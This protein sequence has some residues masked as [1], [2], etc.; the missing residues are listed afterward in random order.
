MKSKY[1]K[2]IIV[3][4][5][6]IV[7]ILA[8]FKP[9]KVEAALITYEDKSVLPAEV[10]K[11]GTEQGNK[12]YFKTLDD[13]KLGI[14]AWLEARCYDYYKNNNGKGILP[15]V[16]FCQMG[17]ET[18]W[19][20]DKSTIVKEANNLLCLKGNGSRG[21]Y[22]LSKG[23]SFANFANWD[24]C[25]SF[26]LNKIE[27]STAN[28][29]RQGQ[30][31]IINLK[32]WQEQMAFICSGNY[33]TFPEPYTGIYFAN[34]V[35][36]IVANKAYILDS[37]IMKDFFN[38]V[39][40]DSKT[41][42]FDIFSTYVKSAERVE[43]YASHA[44]AYKGINKDNVDSSTNWLS[45]P[46]CGLGVKDCTCGY[47]NYTKRENLYSYV[48]N[49]S[50]QISFSGFESNN[51]GQYA[52]ANDIVST[53]VVDEN[54]IIIYGSLS[55]SNNLSGYYAEMSDVKNLSY[56]DKQAISIIQKEYDRGNISNLN[57][58]FRSYVVKFGIIL[59]CYTT[60]L[61][62]AYLADY[63]NNIL[64][65][66]FLKKVSFGFLKVN[67]TDEDYEIQSNR[68]KAI[69]L[70]HLSIIL[71]FGYTISYFIIGGDLFVFISFII[72]KFNKLKV[73]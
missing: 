41:K 12:I 36:K 44:E 17:N 16:I 3:F 1:N 11:Y 62:L 30:Y 28:Y 32:S 9:I 27:T 45:N 48:K 15:S 51:F 46:Y 43:Y 19:G 40:T 72:K 54:D 33:C 50:I 22:V 4:I 6:T 61:L 37:K 47:C 26:Y 5:I 70:S 25:L 68:C 18:G 14:G 34:A 57:S 66:E 64:D 2:K 69:K 65:V 52:L 58:S 31:D 13:L 7:N 59:A 23:G 55:A 21:T 38:S 67:H 8:I 10:R 49:G 29:I 42:A 53:N 73:F 56:T 39:P 63:F 71:L 24:E 20:S 35:S 60:V